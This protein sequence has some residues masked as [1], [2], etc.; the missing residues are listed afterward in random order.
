MT[1]PLMAIPLFCLAGCPL[2]S[3][4]LQHSADNSVAE[5]RYQAVQV[6]NLTLSTNRSAQVDPD[7]TVGDSVYSDRVYTFTEVGAL[8]GAAHILLP[9]D[10][11]HV[12]DVNYVTFT[13]NVPVVVSVLLDA[14][15]TTVPSWLG[16][17]T[18]VAQLIR[19]TDATTHFVVYEKAL[20]AGTVALGDPA[21][22]AT[23][24]TWPWR[25]EWT[26]ALRK[27]Q[28]RSVMSA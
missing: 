4:A 20:P 17:F 12:S 26:Q 3:A 16:S 10:D 27:C 5:S 1:R 14:R 18:K 15:T 25:C 8:D 2:G 9:N 7:L 21:E 22:T 19:T 13:V 28:C 6:S 23:G 24:P 11:K